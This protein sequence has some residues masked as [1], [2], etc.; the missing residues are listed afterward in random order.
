MLVPEQ[1]YRVLEDS[2]GLVIA[3]ACCGVS[4]RVLG[5]DYGPGCIDVG[6]GLRPALTGQG[7]GRSA[8]AAVLGWV[9]SSAPSLRP[10]VT[11]AAFNIR[12]QRVWRDMGLVETQRF[13]RPSDAAAFVILER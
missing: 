7:L 12:A 2:S 6:L 1:N 3:F 11:I 9:E 8:V 13:M 4:A 10:R 5:W